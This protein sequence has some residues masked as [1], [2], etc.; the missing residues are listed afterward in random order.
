MITVT[1]AAKVLQ[2]TRATVYA[3]LRDG[4][5]PD[6]TPAGLLVEAKRLEDEAARI[7][8]EVAEIAPLSVP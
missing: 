3:W 5:I 8:A 4:R 7:R 2:I 1:E 6:T